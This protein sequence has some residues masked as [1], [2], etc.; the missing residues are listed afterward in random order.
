MLMKRIEENEEENEINDSSPRVDIKTTSNNKNGIN[1]LKIEGKREEEMNAVEKEMNILKGI[2]HENIVKVI[3]GYETQ[4]KFL[5]IMELFILYFIF[6]VYHLIVS[7][8]FFLII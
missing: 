8:F 6:Y 2:N 3:D 4:N 5:I 7:F 1:K